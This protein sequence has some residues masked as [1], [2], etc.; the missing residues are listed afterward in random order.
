MTLPNGLLSGLI[1]LLV[2]FG[3]FKVALF[4]S[5]LVSINTKNGKLS[6]FLNGVVWLSLLLSIYA[7]I[8]K[9]AL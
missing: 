4:L 1:I 8:F 7:T 3:G 6:S 9:L 5:D 2:I